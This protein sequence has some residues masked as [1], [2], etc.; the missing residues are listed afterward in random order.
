MCG[1]GHLQYCTALPCTK[2]CPLAKPTEATSGDRR[3]VLQVEIQSPDP[4]PPLLLSLP[5]TE[6]ETD[7][8][9]NTG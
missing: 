8:A 3:T 4:F 6:C 5:L 7:A 2:L 1:A 9:G